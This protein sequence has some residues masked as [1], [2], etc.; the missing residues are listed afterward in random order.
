MKKSRISSIFLLDRLKIVMVYHLLLLSNR[1]KSCLM[2]YFV[3]LVS[4]TR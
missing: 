1:G 4:L 3:V 2:S